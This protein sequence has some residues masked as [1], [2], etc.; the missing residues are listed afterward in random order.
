MTDSLLVYPGC[1]GGGFLVTFSSMDFGTD[2]L[3]WYGQQTKTWS[4]SFPALYLSSQLLTFSFLV[5]HCCLLS[6]GQTLSAANPTTLSYNCSIFWLLPWIYV[7]TNPSAWAGCDTRSIFKQNLTGFNSVFSFS[8]TGCPTKTKKPNLSYSPIAGC[9]NNLIHTFLKV[10]SSIWNA[11]RFV[12]IWTCVIVSISYNDNLYRYLLPWIYSVW[13]SGKENHFYY[14]NTLK[15]KI[16]S[17]S[18]DP[19]PD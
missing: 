9:R 7:S 6:Q 4:F 18:T 11:N 1:W 17:L 3:S 15:K 2:P 19:W 12:R 14:V 16:I 8:L 10:I 13:A 5:T